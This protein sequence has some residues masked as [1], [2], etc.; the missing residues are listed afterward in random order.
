MADTTT[1]NFSL[2]KPEVGASEDTWGTKSNNNLDT[3]DG[4]LG[5]GAPLAIDTVN[6]RVG[7]GATPATTFHVKAGTNQNFN[8]FGPGVFS[9]GVTLGSTTDGFGAYVEMEQRA[10]QFA[11]HNGT[12]ARMRITSAGA[13]GIGCTPDSTIS[14]DVQ[15][16]SASSNNVLLRVKNTTSLEDAGLVIEG[17]N[18]GQREYRIGVNTIANSSDLTFSGPTGYRYYIGS[19][20]KISINSSG[21]LLFNG[22]GVISV[23]SSSDSLYLGGGTNQPLYNWIESGSFTSFKVG[24]SE[25]ARFDASGNLMIGGTNGNPIGNHV[26]QVIANGANGLG[27]HRDGGVPFKAGTDADRNVIEVYRQGSLVGGLGVFSTNNLYVGGSVSGHAG[28]QFGS[29]Q[30]NPMQPAGTASDNVVDLGAPTERFKDLYLSGGVYLG[31]TGAANKLDDYEEGT[32]TPSSGA[33]S[34]N[35]LTVM[36]SGDRYTKIGRQ[37]IAY[38]DI[39]WNS[40]NTGTTSAIITGLPFLP[41]SNHEGDGAATIGY[42]TGSAGV[43][44]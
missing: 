26:S 13:L 34:T 3:L 16:L 19:T 38:F 29:S 17:N 5:G 39:T 35:P 40:G 12:T 33:Q 28:L 37:V 25:R 10:T 31:G 1:T 44:Q 24:G 41:S 8:V 43:C 2:V 4:L 18:G 30:I 21:N 14:L 42:I 23:Q 20:E 7:V 32:L 15:N 9:N 6:N 22:S 36:G 27:V 11:W